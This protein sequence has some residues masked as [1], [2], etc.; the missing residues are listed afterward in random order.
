[1]DVAKYCDQHVRLS[2]CLSVCASVCVVDLYSLC[3]FLYELAAAVAQF[4]VDGS[5]I[6]YVLPRKRRFA[7]IRQVEA[8][9]C[10]NRK[11]NLLSPLALLDETVCC[12][13]LFM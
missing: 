2:V 1:V 13:L 3:G 4:S 12:L 10:R 11:R 7:I 6:R 9:C 5:A 8:P